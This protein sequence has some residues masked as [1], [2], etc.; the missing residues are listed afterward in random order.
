M[1]ISRRAYN[2]VSRPVG[3][4]PHAGRKMW[5]MYGEKRKNWTKRQVIS[6]TSNLILRFLVVGFFVLNPVDI[7]PQSFQSGQ[8]W[9]SIIVAVAIGLIVVWTIFLSLVRRIDVSRSLN[10]IPRGYQLTQKDMTKSMWNR[11]L[12]E[13]E[14]CNQIF[15]SQCDFSAVKHPG[16]QNPQSQS[17]SIKLEAPFAEIIQ[18]VPRFLEEAILEVDPQRYRPPSQSLRQYLAISVADGI[19]AEDATFDIA[20]FTDMYEKARYSGR[21]ISEGSLV[22]IMLSLMNVYKALR[23]PAEALRRVQS[24]HSEIM[25]LVSTVGSVIVKNSSSNNSGFE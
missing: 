5:N 1:R 24:N 3:F 10:R 16:L 4:I 22:D 13:R 14:R 7:L 9:N 25:S 19:M 18:M 2:W 20:D 17:D 15:F 23:L 8:F 12:K 6:T 11:I 21:P